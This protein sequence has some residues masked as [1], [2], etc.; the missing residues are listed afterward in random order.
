MTTISLVS[1]RPV[2]ESQS[3]RESFKLVLLFCCCGLA[4]SI[5]LLALGVDL[6]AAWL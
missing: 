3:D 6:S 4:A 2:A 1:L 5:S